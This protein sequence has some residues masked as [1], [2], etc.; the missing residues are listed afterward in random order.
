MPMY[1]CI[2]RCIVITS[3]YDISHFMIVN[4]PGYIQITACIEF[5]LPPL[6]RYFSPR[7]SF[8]SP[9][10]NKTIYKETTC[11]TLG[12]LQSFST[13]GPALSSKQ[14]HVTP[15]PAWQMLNTKLTKTCCSQLIQGVMLRGRD[16][17]SS[18]D[19]SS[20]S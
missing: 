20:T 6:H 2:I 15:A 10:G 16:L 17:S 5:I 1:R 3:G 9:L 18:S 8:L 14:G 12:N 4:H 7:A 11:F 19:N 13:P